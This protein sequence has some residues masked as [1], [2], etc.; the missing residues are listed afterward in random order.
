MRGL[1]ACVFVLALAAPVFAQASIV[2]IPPGSLMPPVVVFPASAVNGA[3]TLSTTCLT[4]PNGQ[5][6]CQGTNRLL[7]SASIYAGATATLGWTGL[8][9]MNAPADGIIQATNSAF[10]SFTRLIL[11]MNDATTNGVGLAKTAGGSLAVV[12]GDGSANAAISAG[13]YQVA[14]NLAVSATAPTV[15]SA[16]TSPSVTANNGSLTFRINVGTGGTATTIVLAL[17]TATTGWNCDG[18]NLTAA[19]ANRNPTGALLQQ[20][21]STTAATLQYQT[22]ATGVALAFVASDI[23]KITCTAF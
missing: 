15:T 11:G 5:T 19:A 8:S 10:T 1:L 3:G 13:S 6:W 23:V 21:S 16:G 18:S 17:P 4:F 7:A 20:S 14:G 2:G 22:V 9:G 12:T